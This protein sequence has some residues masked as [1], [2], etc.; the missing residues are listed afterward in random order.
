MRLSP[1][2]A[3][4]LAALFISLGTVGY[5]ANGGS[6]LLGL[7]NSAT[8]R[9]FLGA[10]FNGTA[11]Q[12][13]NTSTG[14]AATAL[15]LSVAVGH[16]PLKVNS[17]TKV[18][19]LNA[20][21]LDGVDSS[22]FALSASEGWHYVGDTNEPPFQ[23]GWVNYDSA[24]GHATALSPDASFRLDPNGVVHIRGFIK[25]GFVGNVAF[26]VWKKYCP[27]LLHTFAVVSNNAI[28]RVDVYPPNGVGLCGVQITVGDN[29]W[30]SLDGVEY[31]TGTLDSA[32]QAPGTS[33]EAS[34]GASSSGLCG[35]SSSGGSSGT[36]SSGGS[37]GTT[38]SGGS[39]GTSSGAC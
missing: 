10:N 21:R 16:P 38:S 12:V 19:N 14:A 33:G 17:T 9:T 8:Q 29:T 3:I 18:A 20:D 5:A 30:V 39:S 27:P 1:S 31:E 25:S 32:I 22:A 23:A 26:W 15:T 4:S 24:A 34:S 37:S 28:G 2:T 6:F 35:G 11:M 7:I 36:T 13:S